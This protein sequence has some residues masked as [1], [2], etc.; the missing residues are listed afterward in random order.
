MPTVEV[1][2]LMLQLKLSAFTYWTDEA[3][4]KQ[5]DS[6]APIHPPDRRDKALSVSAPAR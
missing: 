4:S 6:D 3:V 1:E 5:C 2:V